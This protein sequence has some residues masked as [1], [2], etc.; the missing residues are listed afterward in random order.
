MSGSKASGGGAEET[1]PDTSTGDGW[2]DEDWGSLE[3]T[4]T[5]AKNTVSLVPELEKTRVKE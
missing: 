2:E 5:P 4:T 1:V 3:E